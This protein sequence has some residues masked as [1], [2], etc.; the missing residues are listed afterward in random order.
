MNYEHIKLEF[1]GNTVVLTLNRPDKLNAISVQTLEELTDAMAKIE[2]PESGARCLMVTGAGRAFCAGAD[3]SDPSRGS[4]DDRDPNKPSVLE[5]WYHPLFIRLR[6]L[7]MPYIAAINGAAAGVGMSLAL[8][9]DMIIAARSAY[10]L[11][12]F[13]RVGLIPDGG[14][15]YLLPRFIGKA[16]AMELS[17]LAERLPA[18]KALEWGLISRVCDGDRLM[19][20]ALELAENLADGPASLA[21]MRKAYW[22]SLGNTYEEQLQLEADLQKQAKMT[23]DNREGELAFREK[24]QPQFKGR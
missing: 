11:Q 17:M 12:A 1:T 10:F 20:E 9:A 14:A 24:R 23:E 16:R 19:A 6:D 8:C 3:L 7:R 18:E 15:T 2:D 13:R 5:K 22:H 4:E 21:I